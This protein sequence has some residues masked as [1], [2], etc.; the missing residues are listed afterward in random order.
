MPEIPH[1]GNHRIFIH[2]FE[3]ETP[4][5][6]F[7]ALATIEFWLKLAYV[8]LTGIRLGDSMKLSFE[9]ISDALQWCNE[10]VACF[11]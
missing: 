10:S 4:K 2:I 6:T 3:K 5:V 11:E 8:A 9:V 7:Q 1:L